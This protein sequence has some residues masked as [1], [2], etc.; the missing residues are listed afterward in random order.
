MQS[1]CAGFDAGVPPEY[2][3]E[4][5]HGG[6]MTPVKPT[7]GFSS[8]YQSYSVAFHSRCSHAWHPPVRQVP[9][10]LTSLIDGSN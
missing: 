8:D 4:K 5:G 10:V 2:L 1:G 3:N 7:L 6:R 9:R